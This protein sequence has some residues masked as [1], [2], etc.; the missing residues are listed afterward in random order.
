MRYLTSMLDLS[1]PEGSI[2]SSRS[3]PKSVL[4]IVPDFWLE[5]RNPSAPQ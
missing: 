3:A 2:F 4:G 1:E 5:S